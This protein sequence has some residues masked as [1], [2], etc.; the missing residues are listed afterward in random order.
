VGLRRRIALAAL[1][2]ALHGACGSQPPERPQIRLSTTDEAAAEISVEVVG[3][4]KGTLASLRA[5]SPS[6]AE[7]TATFA[8]YVGDDLPDA[9]G[10]PPVLGS[11]AVEKDRVRFRPRFPL[12]PGMSYTVVWHSPTGRGGAQPVATR[13]VVALAPRGGGEAAAV[14]AVHPG[15]ELLPENQLKLYVHFSTAMRRGEAQRHLHLFEADGEEVPAPFALIDREL[16]DPDTTRLTVF[17][18]PGRTKRGVGP[19][20][21][22]GPPLRAGRA[23]RLLVDRGW[24]DAAGRPLGASFEKRFRVVAP[25]RTQPD[26]RDWELAPPETRHEALALVFPEPM[27]RALLERLLWVVDAGGRIVAGTVSIS[28]RERRWIFAPRAFWRPGHY[29]LRVDPGLEDLAGNTL[30]RAFETPVT[31]AVGAAQVAEEIRLR[32]RVGAGSD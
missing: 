18:D 3:L 10:I 32:F 30:R 12:V 23:Y 4:G 2:A 6:V 16:W 28:D 7:W 9:P 25:D 26:P 5:A 21:E 31:S 1:A 15:A 14:T 20:R 13:A 8:V 27:D 17:F 24:R 22:V 19:N 29:E 11:Y